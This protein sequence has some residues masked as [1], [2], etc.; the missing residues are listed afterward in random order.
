MLVLVNCMSRYC[1]EIFNLLFIY[2][3]IY[4]GYLYMYLYL[5]LMFIFFGFFKYL[6]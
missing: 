1:C 6:F 4:I 2:I 3:F 5:M